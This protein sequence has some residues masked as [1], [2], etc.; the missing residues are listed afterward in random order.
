MTMDELAAVLSL[1]GFSGDI[2][3]ENYFMSCPYAPLPDSGHKHAV[4]RNPSFGVY[5]VNN[6]AGALYN[7]FACGRRGQL[8]GL[9]DDMEFYRKMDVRKAREVFASI[10]KRVKDPSALP[11][12]GSRKK[13]S[14]Y[15][16]FPETWLRPYSGSVP[17]YILQRGLLPDVLKAHEVGHDKEAHRVFYPVRD[18]RGKLV[19]AVGG[20]TR[21]LEHAPKYL[22]YWHHIHTLCGWP[23]LPKRGENAYR[24]PSCQKDVEPSAVEDGFKKSR[25]LYRE[26]L[27]PKDGKFIPL[28]VE[29]IVDC[30]KVYQTVSTL[31]I[32]VQ[33]VALFG[34]KPSDEQIKKLAGFGSRVLVLLD[35]D[36]AGRLGTEA[37]VQSLGRRSRLTVLPYPEDSADGDDPGSLPEKTLAAMLKR[38]LR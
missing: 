21:K 4:D 28:V 5:P 34:S 9:L 10:V 23:V 31:K 33:P 35:N 11:S 38:A 22:N 37:F 7:C 1:A 27:L 29:G 30:L 25:F 8:T 26:W 3:A 24:C 36:D 15:R 12:Y 19:G 20:A 13:A 32:P 2:R 6:S 16:T 14:G 18:A 17:R